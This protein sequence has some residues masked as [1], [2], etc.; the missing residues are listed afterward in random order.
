MEIVEDFAIVVAGRDLGESDRLMTFITRRHGKVRAV[1]KGA[2]RS[3]KRFLNALEPCTRLLIRVVPPRTTGLGRLDSAEITESYPAIRASVEKFMLASLCCELADLWVREGDAHSDI[4]DLLQWYMGMMSGNTS[5]LMNTIVFKTRILSMA[6]YGQTWDQC[7]RCGAGLTG[8]D[9]SF[10]METGGCICS[11]CGTENEKG[12]RVTAG[13]V[14]SLAFLDSVE[15]SGV[16]RLRM[17]RTAM[18]EAWRLL[19]GL[20]RYHLRRTPMSYSVLG[21]V[22]R[23]RF[24]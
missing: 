2:R 1:A 16:S 13:T 8:P 14:K 24:Q 4:F 23:K 18:D 10:S 11:S 5:G 20:H 21:E 9:I 7:V 22:F 6:G 12:Y 15:L 17:G 19:A 3:R